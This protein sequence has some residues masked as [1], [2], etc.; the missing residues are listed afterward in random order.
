MPPPLLCPETVKVTLGGST[1][2]WANAEAAAAAA[3]A[4]AADGQLQAAQAATTCSSRRS[5]PGIGMLRSGGGGGGGGDGGGGGGNYLAPFWVVASP[6][7]PA[8]NSR[9]CGFPPGDDWWC[10]AAPLVGL[11]A[12]AACAWCGAAAHGVFGRPRWQVT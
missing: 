11:G 4:S 8:P 1:R 2:C 9:G 3:A 12:R 10:V 5:S 6:A 7:P